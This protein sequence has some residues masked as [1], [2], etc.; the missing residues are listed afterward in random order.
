MNWKFGDNRNAFLKFTSKYGLYH[1]VRT[2]NQDLSLKNYISSSRN[3]KTAA[4][5]EKRTR[6]NEIF[7]LKRTIYKGRRKTCVSN[8]TDTDEMKVDLYRYRKYIHLKD[9]EMELKM[10]E[11]EKLL[12][13]RTYLLSYIDVFFKQ[14][15]VLD[16]TTVHKK[17]KLRREG[18]FSF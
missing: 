13:K 15:I 12:S 16:E 2:K 5:S 8:Q 14:C 7:C 4:Y 9:S 1:F 10:K 17:N 18:M 6:R 3:A 11:Y